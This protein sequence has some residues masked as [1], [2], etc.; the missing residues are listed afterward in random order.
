MS[1]VI[2]IDEWP[3]R[4]LITLGLAPVKQIAIE[5]HCVVLVLWNMG[6][7]N[8]KDKFKAQGATARVD[9][10]DLGMNYI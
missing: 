2:A 5:L 8:V 9:R 4:S 6:Q 3:S 1:I 7:G 10:S